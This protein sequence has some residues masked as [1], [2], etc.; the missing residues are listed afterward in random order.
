MRAAVRRSRLV[1]RGIIL[2]CALLIPAPIYGQPLD[3]GTPRTRDPV[4]ASPFEGFFLGYAANAPKQGL[5]LTY[6]RVRA[7]RWGLYLDVKV[8]VDVPGSATDDYYEDLTAAVAE[9]WGHALRDE[10]TG[11]FSLNVGT[12][13][14]VG[15]AL[16]L[17][18]AVGL[19]AVQR[20]ARYYDPDLLL[21][22]DGLYWIDAEEQELRP[23]VMVGA[24]M[25]PAGRLL[26]QLGVERVPR[27]VT[28]GAAWL[29][30]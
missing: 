12:T 24:L 27:G 28:I 29:T 13:R 20:Y 1:H 7:D 14:A 17:Y 21:G 6:G 15:R 23:N 16:A 19:S 30:R 26:L 22:I 3:G 10:K 8:S 9:A 5:G 25:R 2:A 18:G 11:Y 4:A